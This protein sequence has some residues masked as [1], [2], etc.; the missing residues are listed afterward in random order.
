MSL[1]AVRLRQPELNKSLSPLRMIDFQA[2]TIDL[3][4]PAMLTCP[5]FL[6]LHNP[7]Q[8]VDF[9]S[10]VANA[11]LPRHG[12]FYAHQTYAPAL[13]RCVAEIEAFFPI[14]LKRTSVLQIHNS[15]DS[16]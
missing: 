12:Y 9:R 10:F 4:L 11:C 15:Y 13:L 3:L 7:Y 16:P 5:F 1:A 6:T 14:R 8:P 2:T